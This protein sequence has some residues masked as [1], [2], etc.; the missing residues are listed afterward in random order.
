MRPPYSVF[1]GGPEVSLPGTVGRDT[2]ET[3]PDLLA[4]A[5]LS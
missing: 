3:M 2:G 5:G 4:V 1:S